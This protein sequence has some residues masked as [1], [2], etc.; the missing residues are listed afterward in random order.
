M[1]QCS[2]V[3][4]H[5]NKERKKV[6]ESVA[7]LNIHIS[8]WFLKEIYRLL[9]AEKIYY[10][11]KKNC[12]ITST[13]SHAF[14]YIADLFISY[15]IEFS[16]CLHFQTWN[17]RNVYL[18]ERQTDTCSTNSWIWNYFLW[19]VDISKKTIE[20]KMFCLRNCQIWDRSKSTW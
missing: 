2:W 13:S 11:I 20:M 19:I 3:S 8:T 16:S 15:F 18:E 5:K 1:S 7:K 4:T 14:R 10:P 12:Y 17:F 9:L 6:G